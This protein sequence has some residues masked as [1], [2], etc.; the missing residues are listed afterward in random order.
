[1]PSP[2][3]LPTVI[4]LS[5]EEMRSRALAFAKN[6]AGPQREEAEGK[7]FLDQFFVIFGRERRSVDVDA[8]FEH[9]VEREDRGEGRIDLF[10]KGKLLVEMKSTGKDLSM[11]KGG[12]ARQAFDY[13]ADL[14]ADER[15]RWVMVCDF[16]RFV[17]Y[18]LGEEI[19]DYLKGLAPV[20]KRAPEPVAA[21]LLRDLPDKLRHFAFIRDEEQALFQTQPD[22]NLKAVALLGDLHDELKKSGYSGHRLERFLVRVLF[23]LFAEDTDIFEWNSFT[24][25]IEKSAKD[26]S[27]LG[28]RLAQLFQVLDQDAAIRSANLA[29]EFAAFPYVNGGLFAERLDI[30]DMTAAQ[31]SALLACCRFDWSRISPGVFGSLFQG[32]MDKK[33][34]RAKGAHYTAEEN[35]RRVI[36]PLF[37]DDLRH[38]VRQAPHRLGQKEGARAIPRPSRQSPLPRPRLRLR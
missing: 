33:E 15:P 23:C 19:H 18:D 16:A 20:R 6:W 21:F 29:P 5:R 24:R 13:I 30:A 38:R 25:F 34:R 32:V 27:N 4:T 1:M 14:D 11:E 31:R 22:V 35:I 3:A 2:S 28:A 7:S 12:A 17:I 36:D 8:Q 26:G 9:R 10:W 37:L